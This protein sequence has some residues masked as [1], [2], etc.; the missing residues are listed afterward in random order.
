ME[1]KYSKIFLI[2]LTSIVIN[3]SS[4]GITEKNQYLSGQD[5][6][7]KAEKEGKIL[8]LSGLL[9]PGVHEVELR[10]ESD[11]NNKI[12]NIKEVSPNHPKQEE[13]IRA[14]NQLS[15]NIYYPVV[16][17]IV[18]RGMEG[19]AG[20]TNVRREDTCVINGPFYKQKQAIQPWMIIPSNVL[21]SWENSIFI[22]SNS[23]YLNTFFIKKRYP[24]VTRQLDIQIQL[25][26]EHW[27][28]T[29]SLYD[30]KKEVALFSEKILSGNYSAP[31]FTDGESLGRDRLLKA[32]EGCVGFTQR[33]QVKD[34]CLPTNGGLFLFYDLDAQLYR[35]DYW[36]WGWGPSVAML[37]K[38]SDVL[39]EQK[40][41]LI[42]TAKEIGEASLRF[43]WKDSTSPLND[44]MISRWNRGLTNKDG[45]IGNI[46]VADALFMAGWAWIPLYESTGDKR[47]LNATAHHCQVTDQLLNKWKI[48]PHSYHFDEQNWTDWVIDETS[49]GMEGFAEIFRVTGEKAYQDGGR[50]FIERHREVFERPDGLWNRNYQ[51]SDSSVTSTGYNVKGLGWAIEGLLAAHR[52]MPNEKYLDYVKKMADCIVKSQ[53]PEGYWASNYNKPVSEVGISEKGT[54]LWSYFFYSLYKA[55]GEK[56]YLD[57]GRKALIWCMNVQYDGIDPEAYGSIV[58]CNQESAVGYR[59]WFNVS[60]NY[61]TAFMGLAILH[62][63]S[64]K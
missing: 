19:M 23:C 2:A 64:L 44:I 11:R 38:A 25:L 58:G 29:I 42:R 9:P 36:V 49:F 45:Y 3:C 4:R 39:T 28:G 6:S 15:G 12:S 22:N 34:P 53:Q 37:L 30:V 52:L 62:E 13:Q 51:F 46:T 48:I 43:L 24:L 27:G 17:I 50:R 21:H 59:S 10:I 57:A 32:L 61:T 55:T 63:L 31:H 56:I 1:T 47:Y 40:S 35:S 54:A 7:I 18:E 26:S 41:E 20:F 16:D 60:C 14:T 33:S 8:F 5:I